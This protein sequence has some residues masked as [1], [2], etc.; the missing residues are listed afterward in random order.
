MLCG[1][2]GMLGNQKGTALVMAMILGLIGTLM[3]SSLLYMARIGAFTSGSSTGYQVALASAHGGMTTFSK[4]IIQRGLE[5]AT[6]SATML[7]Y[8][9]GM[10]AALG[11]TTNAQFTTKLTSTGWIGDGV[12]PATTPDA[13]FTLTFP[14][15]GVAANHSM[16]VNATIRAT[17]LGNSGASSTALVSGGVVNNTGGSIT[18]QHI[19]YLYDVEVQSQKATNP[20]E[21][22]TLVGIYA[23]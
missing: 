2:N 17:S 23:Y 12:Y 19:P 8:G 16:T 13:T 21:N 6:L 22:S 4:E 11:N 5:G 10:T 3:L 20:A 7:N 18:P 15:A 14:G 1:N 9:G